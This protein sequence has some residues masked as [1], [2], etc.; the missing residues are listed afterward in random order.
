MAH[1][2]IAARRPEASFSKDGENG[3]HPPF[4]LGRL[5][6][7]VVARDNCL[8]EPAAGAGLTAA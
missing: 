4:G 6:F 1:S 3:A 8:G 5:T 2:D 7:L